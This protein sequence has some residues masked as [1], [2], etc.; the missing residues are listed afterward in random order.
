MGG[1]NA[2]TYAAQTPDELAGIVL[3]DVGPEVHWD[4]VQRIRDFVMDD[5]GPGAVED[6]VQR[7]RAFNPR[8]DERLLRSSLLHNLRELPDG[9]LT[10]KYDRRR[11]TPEAFATAR[12][13]MDQVRGAVGAITCPSLVIRGAESD[14]FNEMQAAE[15][16]AALPDGRVATVKNAGHTVQGDNPRELVRVLRDFLDEIGH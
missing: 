1:L 12:K 2:M 11:F 3:V 13:S 16:A 10:W 6:F 5:P 15:F 4:G 14:V 7:A 8:R 9:S